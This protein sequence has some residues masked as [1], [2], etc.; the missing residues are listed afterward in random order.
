MKLSLIRYFQSLIPFLLIPVIL[1]GKTD[2]LNI[3]FLTVDDMSCDSIG[4]FGCPV[5]DTSPNIDRLA[6]QG[7][8]FNHAHVQVGNCMPSRNVMQSGRY[9]HNNGV[10]GFYQVPNPK[11]KILPEIL[12]EH[13]Y[14]IGIKGKVSHSTPYHPWD[15][16]VV[17]APETRGDERNAKSFYTLTRKGIEMAKDAGKPFY[18]VMNI[19][20][21]HKPF[22]GMDNKQNVIEDPLKPSRIFTAE[23]MVVPGFLPDTPVVRK[24]LSHYYSSVRRADDCAGAVLQALKDSG[25]ENNTLLMF[26]SDHGMP[27]PFAKTTV[28]HHGTNTPWIVRWPGVV[29]P[30]NVDDRHMVSAVDFAPTILDALGIDDGGMDGRS[31]LPVLKNGKQNGRDFVVKEYNENSGGNRS[32]M[33]S[34]A[35]REYTYIYNPWS[36]GERIF[37]TATTGTLAFKEMQR[38]A[39]SDPVMAERLRVF[40]HRDLEEL[41]HTA[42]DPD[43]LE[44]LVDNPEHRE[45]LEKLRKT[46]RD[47]METTGDPLLTAFEALD[48]PS[49]ASALVDKMQEE[50]DERRAN[51][52]KAQKPIPKQRNDLIRMRLPKT[53]KAGTATTLQIRHTI[54]ADMGEQLIHVTL[55]GGDGKRIDRKVMSVNGKGTVE[56]E[57]MLPEAVAMNS[58][59]FAVFVGKEYGS[60]YQHLS[61]KKLAIK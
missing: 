35:T 53:I 58:V 47:W 18:L 15:W 25:E 32:P 38:L 37:K 41:Y 36:D 22:Y 46:M 19:N 26:L 31:F 30:G 45:T 23:E 55:K 57:F 20:D 11:F 5:P 52:R 7:I 8:R 60:H 3:L 50:S 14:F 17:L 43:S 9:P 48:D 59:Q 49:V 12:R 40:N 51:R 56:V 13:G 39:A 33:R 44:N 16:D 1:A 10:E 6:T 4:A 54:P 42:K 28:W 34:V 27:L 2:P 61:S 24:E 29:K 21:P